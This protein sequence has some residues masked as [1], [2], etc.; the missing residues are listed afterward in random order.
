MFKT[1]GHSKF[2]DMRIVDDV[3]QIEANHSDVISLP[4]DFQDDLDHMALFNKLGLFLPGEKD[5]AGTDSIDLADD[6]TD[7][8]NNDVEQKPDDDQDDKDADYD[9]NNVVM[10]K[11]GTS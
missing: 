3:D 8:D 11:P 7:D 1:E 10:S 6:V 9:V 4:G 5:A 2:L